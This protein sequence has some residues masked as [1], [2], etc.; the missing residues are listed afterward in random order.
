[1]ASVAIKVQAF[2]AI[3]EG[4]TLTKVA[5][6]S[7]VTITTINS[8]MHRMFWRALRIPAG[9][10]DIQKNPSPYLKHIEKL[11]KEPTFHLS[12]GLGRK[13]LSIIPK[14]D[15]SPQYL[16]NMSASLLFKN[17][18]N[19]ANISELQEWLAETGYS[20]KSELPKTDVEIKQV[21]EAVAL[22]EVYQFDAKFVREQLNNLTSEDDE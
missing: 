7:G 12:R 18:F 21:R 4:D 9:Y 19:I 22:L 3:V 8:W 11:E 17:G 16:S 15:I 14:Q 20:L 10:K 6:D 5:K 2:K 13:L 1:M